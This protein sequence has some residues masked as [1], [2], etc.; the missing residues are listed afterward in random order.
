MWTTTDDGDRFHVRSSSAVL[1]RTY[2][3]FISAGS[4]APPACW[5]SAP[6]LPAPRSRRF[7]R[8]PRCGRASTWPFVRPS[9]AGL[10]ETG[11]ASPFLAASP[12][13]SLWPSIN[14]GFAVASDLAGASPDVC[15]PTSRLPPCLLAPRRGLLGD[16]GWSAWWL[17]DLLGETVLLASL[18]SDGW[19]L[20]DPDLWLLDS[21]FALRVWPAPRFDLPWPVPPLDWPWPRADCWSL[22]CSPE[23]GFAPLSVSEL[24]NSE[25]V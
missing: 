8:F 6:C 3:P 20:V 16:F 21:L 1:D 4:L 12:E 13:L 5:V 22:C 17:D 2:S 18:F 7:V 11:L 24:E 9:S 14:F 23:L 15:R 19:A 25:T 10:L